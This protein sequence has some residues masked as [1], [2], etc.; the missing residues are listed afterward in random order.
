VVITIELARVAIAI[1]GSVVV[2]CGSS[3]VLGACVV[4]TYPLLKVIVYAPVLPEIEPVTP[5]ASIVTVP[6]LTV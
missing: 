2:V 5:W 3:T 1:Y 4:N 6:P